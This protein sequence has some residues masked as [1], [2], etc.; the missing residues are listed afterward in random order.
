MEATFVVVGPLGSESHAFPDIPASNC[1][2]PPPILPAF[3]RFSAGLLSLSLSLCS[4]FP[5]LRSFSPRNTA[6]A[7]CPPDS[8][9]RD[10]AVAPP[11]LLLVSVRETERATGIKPALTAHPRQKSNHRKDSTGVHLY[12]KLAGYPS[13]RIFPFFGKGTSFQPFN[14]PLFFKLKRETWY[15]MNIHVCVI[16]DS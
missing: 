3:A 11:R 5:S 6:A 16:F 8:L 7:L 13:P 15:S 1:W 14:F 4:P 12:G 2:L 9:H 10:A